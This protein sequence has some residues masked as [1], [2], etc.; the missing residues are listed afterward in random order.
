MMENRDISVGIDIGGTNT[1]FGIVDEN[2]LVLLKDSMKTATHGNAAQFLSD[3]ASRIHRLLEQMEQDGLV[4]RLVGIGMGAPNAN[5]YTGSIENAPNLSFSGIVP[6]KD[7][8]QQFFP[9]DLPIVVSKDANAAAYG[10]LMYGGARGM[11]HFAMYTLGT[12]VGSGLVVDGKVVYGHD[13]FAGECGHTTIVPE[14]RKCGCGGCGHLETYCSASGMKRTAFELLSKDHASQSQLANY[15]LKALDSKIIAEAAL[16][17]DALA[18]EVFNKTGYWLGIGLANTVCH[19]SPEA[20]FLFGGPTAAGDLLI[21]PTRESLERHLLPNY[22][23]KIQ[24]LTSSLHP[25]DA[26]IIGA[27]A[28]GRSMVC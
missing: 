6:I 13:G 3:L 28:M 20:I 25:G 17:G 10:E 23:G 27:A 16:M 15:S 7:M 22:R 8:M 11:K 12:G 2:G 21:N 18:I 9:A 19:I 4:Y 26:A 14:G 1:A 5:H 24:L